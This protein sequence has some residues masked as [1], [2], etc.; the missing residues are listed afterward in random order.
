[1]SLINTGT[2][3]GKSLKK[4]LFVDECKS[5]KQE[6]RKHEA[7]YIIFPKDLENSFEEISRVLELFPRTVPN[8]AKHSFKE[9]R[10]KAH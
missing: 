9:I 8:A 10:I 7:P 2:P 3:L 6:K 1:M 4:Q 5:L